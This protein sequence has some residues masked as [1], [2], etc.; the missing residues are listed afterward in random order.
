MANPS[1]PATLRVGRGAVHLF[2]AQIDG[3]FQVNAA[4]F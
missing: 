4:S 1:R 2:N 3:S